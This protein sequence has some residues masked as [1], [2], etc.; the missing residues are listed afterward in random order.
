MFLRS[1]V[2]NDIAGY[3]GVGVDGGGIF[4]PTMPEPDRWRLP[5]G[6]RGGMTLEEAIQVIE[7]AVA[8]RPALVEP[9]AEPTSPP[10]RSE[11][12]ETDND[13]VSGWWFLIAA[14]VAGAGAGGMVALLVTRRR[15]A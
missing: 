11:T 6:T 15:R 9:S 13:A 4:F 10:V 5:D 8:A 7:D 12:V 1:Q 14:T 2:P 3:R